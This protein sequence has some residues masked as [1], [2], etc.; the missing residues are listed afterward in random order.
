V[1]LKSA[2]REKTKMQIIT[3]DLIDEGRSDSGGFTR[4]QLYLLGVPRYKSSPPKGWKQKVIGRVISDADAARFLSFAAH[5]PNYKPPPRSTS[6]RPTSRVAQL[7][8]EGKSFSE[9]ESEI[10]YPD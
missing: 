3:D 2:S 5:K 1:V 4:E 9:V 8:S 6:A 7:I 10:K